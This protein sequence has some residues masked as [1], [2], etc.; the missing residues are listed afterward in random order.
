VSGTPVGLI[1]T[2]VDGGGVIG[3]GD[4]EV[5]EPL[6]PAGLGLDSAQNV[7]SSTKEY[8]AHEGES[9][10]KLWYGTGGGGGGGGAG[11]TGG[12]GGGG[13]GTY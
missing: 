12:G 9:I 10:K 3:V 6:H 5:P 7:L 1:V 13:G 2:P 11:G 8:G 4:A